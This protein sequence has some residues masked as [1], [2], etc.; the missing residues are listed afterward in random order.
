MNYPISVCFSYMIGRH[1]ASKG[2][3]GGWLPLLLKVQSST[4]MLA[5]FSLLRG[6]SSRGKSDK[7]GSC[8]LSSN[9]L[10]VY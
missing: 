6:K 10:G 8:K 9:C 4:A 5:C 2:D 7:S 1:V 3:I